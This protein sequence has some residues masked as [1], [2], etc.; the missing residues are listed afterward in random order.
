[1]VTEFSGTAENMA[2]LETR[3]SEFNFFLNRYVIFRE[4]WIENIF[5]VGK[6]K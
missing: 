3:H 1:M 4:N 5:Y 6:G 2:C